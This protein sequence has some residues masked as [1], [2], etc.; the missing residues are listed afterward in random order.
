MLI[1]KRIAD[2][3]IPIQT[4]LFDDQVAGSVLSYE[5]EGEREVSYWL[6]REFWGKGVATQALALYLDVIRERPLYVRAA[7]DNL[8]SIRV[9]ENSGFTD[10]GTDKG[11]ANARGDGIEE[12]IMIF[13]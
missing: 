4:I 8:G 2:E 12:V 7:K 11:Y 3:K 5:L 1:G 13:G 10:Y 6:G 9:L